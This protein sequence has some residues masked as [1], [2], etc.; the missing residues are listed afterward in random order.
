MCNSWYTVGIL[1]HY[2]RDKLIKGLQMCDKETIKDF[3]NKYVYKKKKIICII[4]VPKIFT[5]NVF[6]F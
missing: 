3:L 5:I 2:A 6:I 4:N 1:F